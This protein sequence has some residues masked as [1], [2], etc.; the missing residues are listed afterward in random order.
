MRW[1][2]LRRNASRVALDFNTPERPFSPGPRGASAAREVRRETR[3]E[4][5]RRVRALLG[6]DLDLEQRLDRRAA[7]GA[8]FGLHAQHLG[9]VVAHAH[10]AAREDGG[11][12]RLG[13]ASV[14]RMT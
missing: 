7:D 9:A 14:R 5:L 3:V 8:L 6:R 4:A 10:V 1:R 12:A 13:H 11:V 2:G